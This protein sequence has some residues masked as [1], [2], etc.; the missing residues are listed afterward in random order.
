LL[1]QRHRAIEQFLIEIVRDHPLAEFHER[2]LGKGRILRPEAPQ[3][4]LPAPIHARGH[5]RL[6]IPH[7]VVGLQH[8]HHR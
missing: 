6:R 3:H 8:R 7:L 4:Q 2:A 1:G 5:H